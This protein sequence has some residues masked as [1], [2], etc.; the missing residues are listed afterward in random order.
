MR[1]LSVFGVALLVV[2]AGAFSV[3]AGGG[4]TTIGQWR[5]FSVMPDTAAFWAIDKAAADGTGGVQFTFAQYQS[6]STG[7]FAVYL[8]RN[9]NFDLTGKA[10]TVTAHWT[11]G[12]YVTR[13]YPP[14]VTAFARLE[15]QDVS[16][17]GNYGSNDYWW[18][19]GDVFN[20]NDAS[21]AS[22]KTVTAA[23]S[24]RANWSNLCGQSAIDVT[25][26]PQHTNCV[27]TTDP[28]GSPY[29]GFTSAMK[30]VKEVSLSFGRASRFASGVA[31]LGSSSAIFDMTN[32]VV[33]P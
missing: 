19:S 9:Y 32:F 33:T 16:S 30:N 27:G 15:F 17:T 7:S 11:P 28:A 31:A 1:R 3:A 26:Y 4:Q 23:L 8:E 6:A 24:D 20:L 29:D 13:G 21:Q 25:P 10:I 18:Y 12:A 2:L 22:G 5:V 14:D